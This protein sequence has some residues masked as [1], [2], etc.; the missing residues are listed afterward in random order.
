MRWGLVDEFMIKG[1]F[2]REPGKEQRKHQRAE[3]KVFPAMSSHIPVL[4][5]GEAREGELS[6]SCPAQRKED[7]GIRPPHCHGLGWLQD[8]WGRVTLCGGW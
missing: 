8:Q 5:P 4:I 6:H 1:I 2:C 3:V 7:R